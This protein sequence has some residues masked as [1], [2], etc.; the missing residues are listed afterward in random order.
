MRIK[1]VLRLILAL[2]FATF[3]V[4]FSDLI[5]QVGVANPTLVKVG[6]TL[7]AGWIGFIAFPDIA[8]SAKVVT[9]SMTNF[10]V[11]RFSQEVLNQLMRIPKARLPFVHNPTPQVGQVNITRPMILDTSA[12]IDGK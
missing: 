7:L 3:A 2:I 11:N 5:P 9:L 6:V 4:I 10:L 8:R 12:I 1:L